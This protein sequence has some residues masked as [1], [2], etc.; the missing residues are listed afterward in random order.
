MIQWLRRLGRFLLTIRFG[1]VLMILLMIVMM[2]ATQ[3]EASFGTRAMKR[4]IYGSLWFD[5]GVALFVV[6]LAPERRDRLSNRFHASQSG[7]G[8]MPH[9]G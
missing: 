9:A 5:A 8:P 7:A 3:F 4:Y 1:V 2:F 6:H